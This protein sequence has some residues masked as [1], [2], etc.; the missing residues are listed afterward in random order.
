MKDKKRFLDTEAWKWIRT[1]LEIAGII[2]LVILVLHAI[3]LM[4]MTIGKSE[5]LEDEYEVAYAICVKDDIVNVRPFPSTKH[6]A[7]SR[8]EPGD[9]VYLDGKRRNGYAHC[10]EMLNEAGEGWVY[11][12]YLVKDEP[13]LVDCDAVIV[14][15]G[16]LAARKYVNGKRTK[17]L[18]PKA[19]LHVYYRSD[20]WCSTNC[21]YVKTKY[22]ELEEQ[23]GKP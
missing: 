12:G 9:M 21:G 17:W 1:A 8:L 5:A 13:E 19:T 20:E 2:L 3:G 18:K 16:R 7:I 23:D 22:I 4:K 6:E 11:A 10:V 14:S 15:K